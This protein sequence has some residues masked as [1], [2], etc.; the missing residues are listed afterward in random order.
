MATAK[1]TEQ[2]VGADLERL[3]GW[4]AVNGKLHRVFEFDDF[5]QAF[6]FMTQVALA[7]EKMDHHPDWSNSWNK[8][9]VDLSTHSAG[10]LTRNDFD[11]AAKIQ[12]IYGV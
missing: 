7:A 4:S 2:Q 3:E 11:L 5:T 12:H 1:L 10:G 9:T 8:V 6:A